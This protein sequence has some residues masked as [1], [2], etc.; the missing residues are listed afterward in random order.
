MQWTPELIIAL[1][2]A[3]GGLITTIFGAAFS[4]NVVDAFIRFAD[5][6]RAGKERRMKEQREERE[7]KQQQELLDDELNDKGHKFI[8]KRQDRR[9][10]QLESQ[11]GQVQE[12]H[13]V[14][15]QE[16]AVLTTRVDTLLRRVSYLEAARDGKPIPK[17]P[18]NP[19]DS[20][21]FT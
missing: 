12:E 13:A 16:N 18:K 3:A 11:L 20:E 14:C 10:T 15:R 17:P 6:W 1:F 21:S 19:G 5:W 9:I 8:I 4:K 2:A 7:R